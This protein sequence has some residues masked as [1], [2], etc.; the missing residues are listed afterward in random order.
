[1]HME[2]ACIWE[3]YACR[4]RT[5]FWQLQKPFVLQWFHTIPL[6]IW[7]STMVVSV[8]DP[9]QAHAAERKI[10]IFMK[11][12]GGSTL[13]QGQLFKKLTR[14]HASEIRAPESK[15]IKSMK[16]IE[17]HPIVFYKYPNPKMRASRFP[18]KMFL[19]ANP[20]QN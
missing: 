4:N 19:A 3:L 9:G 1:M 12:R 2:I 6:A 8:V 5:S 20:R 11:S 16:T 7:R 10:Q 18:A 15:K 17:I 14:V 13:H